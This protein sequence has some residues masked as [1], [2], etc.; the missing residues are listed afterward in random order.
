MNRVENFI[1]GVIGTGTMGLGV[2]THFIMHGHHVH[3]FSRAKETLQRA[4]KQVLDNLS[5]MQQQG[6]L[7]AAAANTAAQLIS[8][9]T[10]MKEAVSDVDIV[11]ENVPE[12]EEVKKKTFAQLNDF[13]RNDAILASNTSSLNIYDF[14]EVKHRERLVIT[15]FFVPAYVMPLV[16][17]VRGP[18]TSDETVAAVNKLM[19]STG[20][21]PAIV[22]KVVPG[23]IMNRLTFALFRE[24]AYMVGQGWCRPDDIDAAVVS[25][26]GPRYAFEGPFGLVDFA[27]VETY[28]KIAEYLFPELCKDDVV[29][30]VLKSLYDRGKL[31]VKS[32]EGFYQ[33][34]DS[35]K[36]RAHRDEKIVKM[37]QAIHAVNQLDKF[38]RDNI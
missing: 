36:A 23:F 11:I 6:I 35:V 19:T 26:H 21:N 29:P 32:G 34:K 4:E 17:I 16:E 37:M 8:Y 12:N 5:S 24:A 10:D 15:H 20:K 3:L 38:D 30:S 14:L 25:T 27:G 31:G 9:Y 18:A 33:Y 1:I 28:V 7:D 22:N 13:C 2:A